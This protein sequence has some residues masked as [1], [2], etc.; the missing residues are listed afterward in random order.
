M[1]F[2]YIKRGVRGKSQVPAIVS[3]IILK[4]RLQDERSFLRY[5][6]CHSE[7]QCNFPALVHP[8]DKFISIHSLTFCSV[9]FA[10]NYFVIRVFLSEI[11]DS[12]K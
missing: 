1:S 7:F 10:G 6:Y 12:Y 2:V 11:R 4:M 9:I 8:P 3:V 5:R